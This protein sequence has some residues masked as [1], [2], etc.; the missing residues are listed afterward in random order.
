MAVL[1]RSIKGLQ[2]LLDIC[3][4]YCEI[5]DIML[6][7]KKTKNMLFVKGDTPTFH[8]V[9]NYVRIPCVDNWKYLELTL[10]SGDRFSC[11]TKEKLSLFYRVLNGIIR[12]DGRPDKL[13]LR[14]LLEAH[15]LPILTYS[16]EI[17]HVSNR[18][19]RRQL[20]VVYNSI[21]SNI[22]WYS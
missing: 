12:I 5:W 13:V 8:V 10:K 1:S 15:C 7:A 11:C 20:H 14:R 4:A 17:L 9:L 3:R 18:N 2:K 21:Y 16:I 22:F 6:N 19:E